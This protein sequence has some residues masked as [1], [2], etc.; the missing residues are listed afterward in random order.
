ME[1]EKK[2]E[3]TTMESKDNAGAIGQTPLH[4][5]NLGP[6][7]PVPAMVRIILIKVWA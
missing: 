1:K 5:T 7:E 3:R 6:F 2:T 4:W